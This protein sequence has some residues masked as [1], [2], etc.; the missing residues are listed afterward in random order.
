MIK[1]EALLLAADSC[2]VQP[3]LGRLDGRHVEEGCLGFLQDK[4]DKC[5]KVETMEES[6]GCNAVRKDRAQTGL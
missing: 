4:R 1:I 3:K 5:N 2:R 6:D